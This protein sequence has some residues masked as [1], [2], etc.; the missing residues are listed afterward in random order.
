MFS[1]EQNCYFW[2]AKYKWTFFPLCL[3]LG[4][5]INFSICIKLQGWKPKHLNSF[6]QTW[7]LSDTVVKAKRNIYRYTKVKPD[8]YFTYFHCDFYM[9]LCSYCTCP[10]IMTLLNCALC[11][12][13]ICPV[14]PVWIIVSVFWG[15]CV[16]LASVLSQLL[17]ETTHLYVCIS[18]FSNTVWQRVSQALWFLA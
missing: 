7:S 11:H 5:F 18:A 13:D 12:D 3:H 8:A 9:C 14:C 4:I 1:R 15:L 10:L 2:E 6:V 16:Q 17:Y